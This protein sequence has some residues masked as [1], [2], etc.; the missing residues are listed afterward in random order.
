MTHRWVI[1]L[2]VMLGAFG[3]TAR[4]QD[5]DA[6]PAVSLEEAIRRAIDVQPATV[7]ANGLRRTTAASARQALAQYLP[8]VTTGMSTSRSNEGRIDGATGQ[9][10][11]PEYTWTVSLSANLELWDGFR[12][13]FNS[14]AERA[15][16]DAAEAG[17]VTR[18]FEVTLETKRRYYAA[19]ASEELVRVSEAQA[20]R[21]QQQLQISVEKLRAGS[22]TRSD[23]LQ[24]TVGYGTARINLLQARAN[25]AS[26]QAN[27]GSYVGVDGPVRAIRETALPPLPDTVTLRGLAL[28]SAPVIEQTAAQ[29]R[30][31][32]AQVWA[33]RS[34][35]WPTLTVAYA[36]DHL[37]SRAGQSLGSPFS[38]FGDYRESFRWTF[39]L[40]LPL[41]NRLT[42][43]TNQVTARVTRDNAEAGAANARR[44]V[45]A[46]LTQQL[47]A[48]VTTYEQIEIARTNL[49][50]A[51]EDLRVQQERYR[52]GAATILDL[53]TS[54]ATL[55]GAEQNEVQMRFNYLIARAQVEALIGR[56]L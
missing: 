55:T 46:A 56:A 34:Q 49:A 29:S 24:S 2:A 50:A 30:A 39:N 11:P 4:A 10:I 54:Q 16:N 28:E 17:Y 25:F 7:Q 42:R 21:A 12:R 35:Y 20:R 14:R 53:L 52:V 8:S 41:F 6:V 1:S 3:T 43:E 19:L 36:D 51:T 27:L 15:N 26:A 40:S 22:A 38:N 48:L 13:L 37:G 5:T 23:S 18:R 33:A 9:P 31:A 32:R 47:A 44:D 45:S